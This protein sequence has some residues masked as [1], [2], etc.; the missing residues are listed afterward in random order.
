MESPVRIY[1]G[2]ATRLGA[3]TTVQEATTRIQSLIDAGEPLFT[4]K[5][6]HAVWQQLRNAD[7]M[8]GV[9]KISVNGLD[10]VAV[11]FAIETGAI[12]RSPQPGF[13]FIV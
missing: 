9:Q 4:K 8:E 1:M 2:K 10:G 7:D 3:P 11:E 5:E 12:H 13:E 6:L